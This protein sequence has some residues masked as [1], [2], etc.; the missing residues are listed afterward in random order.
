MALGG[1]AYLVRDWRTLQLLVSLLCLP[2]LP[3]LFILDESPRWLAVKGYHNYALQV[4]VKAAR[5]NKAVL[6]PPH[7]IL[8]IVKEGQNE[9]IPLKK[10]SQDSCQRNA[11][12]TIRGFFI[13]FRTRRLRTITLAMYIN[14]LCVGMVYFGLSLSGGQLSSNPFA[15]MAL[16]GLVEVPAYTVAIPI[17]ITYGRKY[18]TIFFFLFSGVLLLALPFIPEGCG[19]VRI[20]LAMAG[21]MT[22]TSVFQILSLYSSEL[23]PTE[24]RTWGTS[25][26][27]MMS[28]LGST[29]SPFIT[30]YLGTVYPWAP[31]AVFGALSLVAGIA[32]LAL[33][34]TLGISLPDT[35]DHLENRAS[36]AVNRNIFRFLLRDPPNTSPLPPRG[37]FA[38][39]QN[40]DVDALV[41]L[42]PQ[43]HLHN[44]HYHQLQRLFRI[45]RE[46]GVFYGC[47][48]PTCTHE[49]RK[50][51]I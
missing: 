14:Y 35:I 13:L 48:H 42:H 27:F 23:F 12:D 8:Q 49:K 40:A 39:Q 41:D 3:A 30:E 4:L 26:A 51:S 2:F 18:P 44:L 20:T 11:L 34:E 22:I 24:V 43:H 38:R 25:T 50:S 32:T 29:A 10:T 33:P 7:R 17:V 46:Q 37:S 1:L 28:R 21:K 45:E 9:H 36:L 6:P 5:W 16:M 31:S 19:W 15:Y 47:S